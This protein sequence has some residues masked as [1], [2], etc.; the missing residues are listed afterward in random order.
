MLVVAMTMS[1]QHDHSHAHQHSHAVGTQD[2]GETLE[3]A[4][5]VTLVV[6]EQI[7]GL[8]RGLQKLRTVPASDMI[9]LMTSPR[10]QHRLGPHHQT[11]HHS[12]AGLHALRR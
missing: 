5:A 1:L 8:P 11:K 12:R 3:A 10:L 9:I 4:A 2:P 6:P 7:R